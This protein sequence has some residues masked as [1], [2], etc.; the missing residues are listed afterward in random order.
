MEVVLYMPD[1][2]RRFALDKGVSLSEAYY[3]GGKTLRLFSEFFI[4]ERRAKIFIY[5]ALSDYTYKRTDSS[6]DSIYTAA[7]RTFEDLLKEDF[8]RKR[9]I[10]LRVIGHIER[11]PVKLKRIL[12]FLSDSTEKE[13]N[14]EIIILFGY[15]LEEDINLALSQKPKDYHSF[16]EKLTLPEI[17]LVIRPTE[18]RPS[19]G[20]VYAMSQAQMMTLD[21][22]NPEISKKDLEKVWQQYSRLKEFRM[23]GNPYHLKNS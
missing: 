23:R 11:L 15:S 17:D 6:L 10:K 12:K 2:N 20:P 9:G 16:R 22:L 3:L 18:M 1:G 21:K 7:L 19:G 8:F 4:V 5:H 14:G 13:K